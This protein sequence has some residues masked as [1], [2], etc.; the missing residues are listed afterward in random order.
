MAAGR[1]RPCTVKR[2]DRL[3]SVEGEAQAA[4][5]NRLNV[6]VTHRIQLLWEPDAETTVEAGRSMQ[7]GNNHSDDIELWH[8]PIVARQVVGS[9]RSDDRRPYPRQAGSPQRIA[10][11]L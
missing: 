6:A 11:A 7:V 1:S 3:L 10:D 2:L 9:A 4:R 5:E 8:E